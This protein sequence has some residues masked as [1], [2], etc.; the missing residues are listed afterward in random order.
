[1]RRKRLEDEQ[2]KECTFKPKLYWGN[3]VQTNRRKPLVSASSVTSNRTLKSQ[4]GHSSQSPR[5]ARV[6]ASKKKSTRTFSHRNCPI[7]NIDPIT[8]INI[9]PIQ[10][11][12]QPIESMDSPAVRRTAQKDK[13]MMPPL[14]VEI[15]T[16]IPTSIE[17]ASPVRR[18]HDWKA[19]LYS[20]GSAVSPLRGP[21][22]GVEI[23]REP[24]DSPMAPRVIFCGTT[25]GGESA[26]EQTQRTDY[27]SI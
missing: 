18:L 26:A 17:P 8:N 2:L 20:R 9:S 13:T 1:M 21:T 3:K 6:S 5:H 14:P 15:T 16:T 19:R 24:E 25:V 10:T 23:D 4:G 11:G 22:L 7:P 12:I 27:G